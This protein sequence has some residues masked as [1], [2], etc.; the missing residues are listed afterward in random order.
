LGAGK[1]GGRRLTNR[2]EGA[3]MAVRDKPIVRAGR[4][5]EPMPN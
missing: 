3:S 5:F 4:I 1:R 2:A